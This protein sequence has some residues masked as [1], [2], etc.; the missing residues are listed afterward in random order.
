M[1]SG[2]VQSGA[3]RS[4]GRAA[5]VA[6]LLLLFPVLVSA[7]GALELSEETWNGC[8]LMAEPVRLDFDVVSAEPRYL[9]SHSRRQIDSMLHGHYRQHSGVVGMTRASHR[10]DYRFEYAIRGRQGG[11]ACVYLSRLRATFGFSGMEVYVAREYAEGSCAYNVTLQHENQHVQINRAVLAR[12]APRIR[13]GLVDILKRM[14]PL[15]VADA[16]Q[17]GELIKQRLGS[18]LDPY[19]KAFEADRDAANATIDTPENYR[20]TAALCSDW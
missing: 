20:R 11:G 9:R 16:E 10:M 2:T 14:N 15:I 18:R 6:L 4:S 7:A 17:A 12:Q 5:A 8:P 3:L 1:Q 19:L 13:Q